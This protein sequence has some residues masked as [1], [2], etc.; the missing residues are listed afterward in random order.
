M[1]SVLFRFGP[2]FR[3]RTL[4]IQYEGDEKIDDKQ[5]TQFQTSPSSSRECSPNPLPNILLP[6]VG[7]VVVCNLSL[8]SVLRGG[9]V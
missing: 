1:G 8:D 7:L 4:V 2:K 3:R 9:E 6:R 5:H